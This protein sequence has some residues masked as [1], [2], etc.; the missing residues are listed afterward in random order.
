MP[1]L[2]NKVATVTNFTGR[3]LRTPEIIDSPGACQELHGIRRNF[4]SGD[5]CNLI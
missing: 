2:L 3:F 1:D 5:N 4:T